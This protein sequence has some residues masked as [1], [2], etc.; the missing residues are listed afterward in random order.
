[1]YYREGQHDDA[2]K[3]YAKVLEIAAI[4]LPENSSLVA[5]TF[6]NMGLCYSSQEKYD[7]AI[8]SM[9]KSTEQF[10]KTL[11]PDHPEILDN[12]KYIETIR[13]KKILR[14]IFNGT[15]TDS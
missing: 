9:E 1:M 7:E 2:L 15:T 11:P 3:S 5:V 6:F 14:D 12:K 13:Q 4:S 10:L 8:E